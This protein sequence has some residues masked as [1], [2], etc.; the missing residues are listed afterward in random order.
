MLKC[1]CILAVVY[2]HCIST[3]F[4]VTEFWGVFFTDFTRFAVPGF[5]FTAGFLFDKKKD[6]T[7]RLIGKKLSRLLPPYLFCSLCI[8]FL[9]L[10]GVNVSLENLSPGQLAYNLIFG[11]TVGIYYF[12]F[13]IFYLFAGSFLLRHVP[14]KWVFVLWGLS[15]ILLILFVKVWRFGEGTSFF[16]FLRHPFFH[17]FA[18]LSGWTY[19]LHYERAGSFLKKYGAAVFCIGMALMLTILVY[20]RVDNNNFNSYPI[21]AQLYIYTCIMLLSVAG[22][23]NRTFQGGIHFISDRSYGIFLLHFPFVRACQLVYPEISAHYSFVYAFISW[24]GGIAGSLLIIFIVQKLSGRYSKY[25]VG[26]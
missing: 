23:R 24:C 5:F 20:T 9:N 12:V 22:M 1:V 15:A 8:Q 18:Y 4:I 3:S 21:L 13:V 16:L 6:P 25:L 26:C 17:L 7:G 2:I 19:A 14:P 10:P 11:D